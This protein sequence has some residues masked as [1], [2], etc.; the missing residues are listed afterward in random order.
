M[1]SRIRWLR[2]GAVVLLSI[3][4]TVVSLIWL[5]GGFHEKIEPGPTQVALLPF[6]DAPTV[7]VESIIAV[8]NAILLIEFV[9]HAEDAGKS[10][11]EA[12]IA[13][14]AL[15]LRPVFLT[16]GTAMLAAWPITLDPIFNRLAWALIFGL[17]VSTVFTPVVIPV[18]Y[19]MNSNNKLRF[20]SEPRL[21]RSGHAAGKTSPRAAGH[22]TTE[23]TLIMGRVLHGLRSACNVAVVKF[24]A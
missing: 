23:R 22:A 12:L 1:K 16:A 19:Y 2:T 5:A 18:V 17:F 7:A 13:S 3:G 24:A 10:L 21:S 20:R 11:E 4:G 8:R 15:Q 9:H 6:E 14:G